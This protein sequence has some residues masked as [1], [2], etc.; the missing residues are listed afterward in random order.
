MGKRRGKG[1]GSIYR[2]Q[3]GRWAADIT[4]EGRRRKTLYGRT[5]EEVHEKLL[6]AQNEKRQ[7]KLRSGPKQTVRDYLNYWLEEIHRPKIKISTYALYRLNLDNHLIPA[8]G[9]IQLHKLT[10]DQVQSF[11]AEK[12]RNGYKPGTV[13]LM[14]SILHAELKDAVRKKRLSL[15]VCDAVDLPRMIQHEIQPLT[16][17]QA[18]ILLAA[19]RQGRL[20]CLLTVALVTGMRLGELLAL[21]WS[22]VD[23]TRGILQ[24]RRTVNRIKGFGIT[25]SE[26]K[27]ESSKRSIVLPPFVIDTLVQH[28][29]SHNDARI[30][31]GFKWQELGL[32]FPNTQGG[33]MRRPKLHRMYKKLLKVAGLPDIRFHDLRHSAATIF[34]SMG[35]HPKIVQEVLGHSDITLTLRVYSHVL[36]SM[37]QEAMNKMDTVFG[38]KH[39]YV[40]S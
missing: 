37:Q 20:E 31:A 11:C 40:K 39:F 9:H 6:A 10:T 25:E 5:R 35:V 12:L 28:R 13:R 16:M 19:A 14:Y 33:Y 8:L 27:T 18:H 26:P 30:K 2:R 21:R 23:M 24:V 7:G 22:E 1:E 3:D 36:P 15:N 38:G 29:A 32:V 4:I 17:E 34:L